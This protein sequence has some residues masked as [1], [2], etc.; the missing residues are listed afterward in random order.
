MQIMPGTW[1]YLTRRYGLGSDPWNPRLNMIGGALYLA[2]MVRQFGYPGAYSAYNAGP[3]RY[4]RHVRNGVPLPP[5]TVAYTAQLTGSTPRRNRGQAA[6]GTPAASRWQEATLFIPP[7]TTR[8]ARPEA[9]ESNADSG[10]GSTNS[11]PPHS[12]FPLLRPGASAFG[13]RSATPNSE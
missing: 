11:A 12:L 2:E 7:T 6:N 3:G 1:S 10:V 13:M 9:A 4:Q 8:T 5:E